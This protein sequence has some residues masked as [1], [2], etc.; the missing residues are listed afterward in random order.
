[1][2]E[3]LDYSFEYRKLF[4]EEQMGCEKGRRETDDIDLQGGQNKPKK[5]SHSQGV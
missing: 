5:C 3:K 1:M 4:P 2:K